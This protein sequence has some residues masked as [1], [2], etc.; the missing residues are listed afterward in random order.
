MIPTSGNQCCTGS[1]Q[2]QSPEIPWNLDIVGQFII[3]F[4]P[5]FLFANIDSD[6]A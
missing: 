6:A 1:R 2:R 3:V 4:R 5:M